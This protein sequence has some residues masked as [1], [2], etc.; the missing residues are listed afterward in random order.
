MAARVQVT[1]GDKRGL[2][3]D[4][5]GA[6]A[7]DYVR[8]LGRGSG[9]T[10]DWVEIEPQGRDLRTF[11]H[12]SEISLVSLVEEDAMSPRIRQL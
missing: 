7:E 9:S 11:V 2:V 10:G 4:V 5:E 1:F 6:A 12:A 8:S 3:A